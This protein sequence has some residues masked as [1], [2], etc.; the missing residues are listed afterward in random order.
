MQCHEVQVKLSAYYDAEL[1]TDQQVAVEVH[2]ESCSKCTARL[3]E[4]RRLSQTASTL[5][6]PTPPRQLWKKVE[7]TLKS[8]TD[9]RSS[10]W[11]RRW[12]RSPSA[13]IAA[14]AFLLL[15]AGLGIYFDRQNHTN[16]DRSEEHTSELQSH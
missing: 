15:A 11:S 14:A 1:P 3:A 13:L 9:V 2:L 7:D 16:H 4:I 6:E 8:R 5:P 10:D 12:W